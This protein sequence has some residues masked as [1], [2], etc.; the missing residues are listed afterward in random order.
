MS[1]L[2]YMGIEP[3]IFSKARAAIDKG[4]R[5]DPLSEAEMTDALALKQAGEFAAKLRNSGRDSEQYAA[6]IVALCKGD[7]DVVKMFDD[8][9][10]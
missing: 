6:V 1:D 8:A 5:G 2:T 4:R 3:Y 9:L 10:R 7:P